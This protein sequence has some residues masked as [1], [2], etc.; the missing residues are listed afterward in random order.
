MFICL[1]IL[2]SVSDSYSISYATDTGVAL[3]FIL[4]STGAELD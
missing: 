3:N 4:T 2:Q 1:F